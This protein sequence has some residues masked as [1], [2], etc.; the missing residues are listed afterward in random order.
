MTQQMVSGLPFFCPT[1]RDSRWHSQ[2]KGESVMKTRTNETPAYWGRRCQMQDSRAR[3]LLAPSRMMRLMVLLGLLGSLCPL[4]TAQVGTKPINPFGTKTSLTSPTPPVVGKLIELDAHVSANETVTGTVTFF[5]DQSAIGSPQSVTNGLASIT[6]ILTGGLHPITAHYNG[7]G[8]LLASTSDSLNLDV[9]KS[10]ID[11]FQLTSSQNPSGIG[12]QV[13]FSLPNEAFE[14]PPCPTCPL[15]TGTITYYLD[16]ANQLGPP[17]AFGPFTT[18]F[19]TAGAHRIT[20]R[21]SGDNNYLAGEIGTV[22]QTVTAVTVTSINSY[23]NPSVFGQ[24]VTVTASFD[25][26]DSG[27]PSSLVSFLDGANLLGTA[28]LSGGRAS[29]TTSKLAV[30]VH[31]ITAAYAGDTYLSGSAYFTA[32][33]TVNNASV[34]VPATTTTSVV[35]SSNPS[36]FGQ[37]VTFTAS[38]TGNVTTVT[39]T[40]IT[41]GNNTI[42]VGSS[43]GLSLGQNA[44]AHDAGSN[45]PLIFTG[46]GVPSGTVTFKDGASTLGSAPLNGGQAIF[47]TLALAAGPHSITAVYSGDTNFS[48]STSSGIS[49]TVTNA[50]VSISTS[51]SVV[52]S[53]NP[54]VFGQP[55]TFAVNV[56][57]SGSGTPSASVSFLDGANTLGT[58]ALSGGRASF[59]TSTLTVGA[60]AITAVYSG[61]D[62]FIGSTS[63]ALPQTISA[64]G[65]VS[66]ATV[67]LAH[68]AAGDTWTT[69]FFVINTGNQ[70]AHFSISFFDDNGSPATLPFSSGP[71]SILSGSVPAN[72]SAYF[73]AANPLA[74]L[75]SGSGHIAA[76]PSIVIQALFRNNVN[77]AYYE[78]AVP[79]ISGT[80]EFL[81]PFDATT[82]AANGQPF[83]T[84]FA[85]A[86]LDQAP[87]NVTCIARDPNG[88]V[89]LNAVP[90]PQLRPLGHWANYLFPLLDGQRGTIECTSNTDIAAMAI[91]SIGTNAF[92]SLPIISNPSTFTSGSHPA[93]A[94]FAAGGSWT[95]G[96]FVLNTG[97]AGAHFSIAFHD[98]N[99]N[100]V[101]LP[102]STGSEN[103]LSGTIAAQGSAYFEAGDSQAPLM[104]GWAQITAD[105]AVVVQ[106]LF[107]DDSNGTYHEAAVPS[108]SGSKE[109][110][111][112]FDTTTFAAN[113]QPFY[114]GFAIANLD[115]ASALVI[116][117]ARDSSG[118]VIPNAVPVPQLNALGHWANYLFPALSGSRGT[119]DCGSNTNIAATALR[120]IGTSAFSSLPV[121]TK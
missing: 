112:P 1:A 19:T 111:M 110:I 9:Q 89:I 32:S 36:V 71:A 84:G 83:F 63:D 95:T 102:F 5:D 38:V 116:C 8:N 3:I 99:G 70:S 98:D 43:T 34:P 85:I 74:A 69:G 103:T 31:S 42:T 107:R 51:T 120:S 119:I 82:F 80:K 57:G 44:T 10:S 60:H 27:A 55:V 118:T 48:A 33:Q 28:P 29:F 88:A 90:V 2:E 61:D 25:G 20:A 39:A 86:N 65:T 21:Y 35:S 59:T 100:P 108:G 96:F 46:S 92:S 67:A 54:S 58:A 41:T 106:A 94:H 75:I 50:S 64:A 56:T 79:S 30:G 117:T 37:P 121:I 52:S 4:L 72:G 73:E 91:R 68:F 45:V 66:T 11:D 18:K 97:S 114:T 113:G 24:F 77:G 13:I 23:P 93:L 101:A 115:E 7:S 17:Q 12:Q 16:G 26:S 105:P 87:A 78:A 109:F 22:A 76:D 6:T 49:Q 62:N 47:S 53:L 104:A 14:D 40:P 15:P 81:L